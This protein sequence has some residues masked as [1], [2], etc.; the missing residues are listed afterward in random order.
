MLPW[1]PRYFGGRAIEPWGAFA[2]ASRECGASDNG[3]G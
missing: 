1:Y 2:Q 3:R